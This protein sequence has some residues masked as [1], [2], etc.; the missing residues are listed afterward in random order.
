MKRALMVL[1]VLAVVS[2]AGLLAYEV[3][4]PSPT[5]QVIRRSSYVRVDASFLDYHL[6]L[7]RF[8]LEDMTVH[9]TLLEAVADGKTREGMIDGTIDFVPGR[10]G[11]VTGRIASDLT[12]VKEF[13]AGD[14][15]TFPE[16]DYSIGSSPC[17]MGRRKGTSWESFSILT[18]RERSGAVWSALGGL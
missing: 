3:F 1:A 6:G 4:L 11:Q 17:R 16:A 2:V 10:D 18:G 15:Y 7:T 12:R 9:R 14:T 8:M 13:K 5:M